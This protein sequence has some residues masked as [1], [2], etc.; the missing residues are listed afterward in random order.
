MD[1]AKLIQSP[2][3]ISAEEAL[4]TEIILN[5]ALVDILITKKIISEDELIS[6]IRK[7]RRERELL[8]ENWD[9]A[10]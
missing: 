3:V 1:M 7:I 9:C 5:Q 2:T 8:A 4:R 10:N 6:N